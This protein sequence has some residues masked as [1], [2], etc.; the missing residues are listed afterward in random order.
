MKATYSPPTH[1][2]YHQGLLLFAHL[3]MNVDGVVDER[4]LKA[5]EEIRK[6]ENIPEETFSVF[7]ETITKKPEKDLYHDGIDMLN[8]C[9]EQERLCALVHLYRLSESDFS[10]HPREV[11]LLL[12]SLKRT[13]VDFDEIEL[14]ARL[15]N[16]RR[17]L[18]PRAA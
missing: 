4:E 18:P 8:N 2:I 5:L 14:T 9:S 16:A 1:S 11:R 13:D 3:L 7:R 17:G 10:I 12:Y 6:E 15:V